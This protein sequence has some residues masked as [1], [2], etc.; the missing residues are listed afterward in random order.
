VIE[1]DALH[2][3]L[4]RNPRG[5]LTPAQEH[6]AAGTFS[7]ETTRT[8]RCST[9]AREQAGEPTVPEQA[10]PG[11]AEERSSEVVAPRRGGHAA[12]GDAAS[13]LVLT[14]YRRRR[15]DWIVVVA[16]VVVVVAGL[17]GAD[18]AGVFRP[19]K[20]AATSNG[21][22]TSTQAVTRGSLT[23]QTQEDGTLGDAGTYTVVVPGS[24]WCCCTGVSRPTA[25]CRRA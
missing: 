18:A 5:G 13:G 3:E 19:P 4:T 16:V 10:A 24:R 22:A 23:E 12:G 20:P 1:A 11:G 14:G 8:I 2:T 15:R 25:T 7:P 9:D 17:G 21:Y 6:G